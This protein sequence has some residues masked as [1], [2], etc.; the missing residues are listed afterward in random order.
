MDQRADQACIAYFQH[1]L[2]ES[3]TCV[4]RG[5]HSGLKIVMQVTP[6]EANSGIVFV[7]RDVDIQRYEIQAN[8]RNVSDTRLSTTI[9][10]KHGVR[11]S[12]VEHLLAALYACGIDNARVLVSG[13]EVPAMDGSALPFLSLIKQA[14]KCEQVAERNALLI[15]QSVSISK[16]DKFAGFLPAPVPWIEC[17]VDMGAGPIGRQKRSLPISQQVFEHELAPARTFSFK[18]QITTL[19]KLG[20]AQGGSVQNSVL[21]ENNAILNN[22]GLRFDDEF[23]RHSMVDA[24]GDLALM[25]VVIVGQFTSHGG[26]HELNTDLIQ[27][28]MANERAW[29]FTSL[30]KA[31]NYWNEI[32]T[33]QHADRDLARM[34]MAKYDFLAD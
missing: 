10:N 3:F 22:E 2:K 26:S 30:R 15:R 18:E 16:A 11:V 31:K 5:M 21:I 17:E 9:V 4:S 14:G 8:W 25:G 20:L 33:Q 29:E 7:R 27:K 12:S 6:A 19:H 32:L 34:I 23:V 1:T 13:P 28:L 24:I